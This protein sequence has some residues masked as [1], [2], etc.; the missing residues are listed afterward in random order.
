[1]TKVYNVFRGESAAKVEGADVAGRAP[2]ERARQPERGCVRDAGRVPHHAL[3]RPHRCASSPPVR[4]LRP[5]FEEFR[6]GKARARGRVDGRIAQ[7]SH[8]SLM[9]LNNKQTE[10][11]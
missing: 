2:P 11:K 10:C 3:R 5:L 4:S 8:S 1:M 6:V 9:S 7:L